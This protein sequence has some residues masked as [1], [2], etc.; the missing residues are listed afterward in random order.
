M[1][2]VWRAASA[3]VLGLLLAACG[4]DEDKAAGGPDE[5]SDS[6]TS[7][8]DDGTDEDDDDT[9]LAPGQGAFGGRV[10][11]EEGAPLE[12]ILVNLCAESCYAQRTDADGRWT[13]ELP[14]DL[15]SLELLEGDPSA[16]TRGWP[17][18]PV[19]VIEGETRIL[20]DDVVMPLLTH[21]HTIVTDRWLEV[22]E[23]LDLYVDPN[24]WTAPDLAPED[25]EPWV[26]GVRVD[27]AAAGLPLEGLEGTVV[28]MWYLA[29]LDSRPTGDWPVRLSGE[30][31]LAPG[32]EA[33]LM[34][35]DYDAREWVAFSTVTVDDEGAVRTANS[36]LPVLSTV[37]VVSP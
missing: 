25:A 12:G 9:G 21:H 8:V 3:G 24:T 37:V 22:G 26:A 20:E 16:P 33:A 4:G 35:A 36:P 32:T 29:P 1:D 23:G 13:H 10:V 6:G 17:L 5:A 30:L 11:D 28:A 27:P 34:V 15:Y 31:G 7:A 14:A 19:T 18:A 2:G